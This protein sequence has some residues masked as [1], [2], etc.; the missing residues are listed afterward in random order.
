MWN[1]LPYY[2][3]SD[4]SFESYF[5]QSMQNKCLQITLRG[6]YLDNWDLCKTGHLQTLAWLVHISF[7]VWDLCKITQ[8]QNKRRQSDDRFSAWVLCKI[9][10]LQNRRHSNIGSRLVWDL[11]KIEYFQLFSPQSSDFPTR[12][13]AYIKLLTSKTEGMLLYVFIMFETYVKSN[14]SKTSST[15]RMVLR[16]M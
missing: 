3:R 14:A 12:F 6:K 2:H 5:L 1:H 7:S 13:V 9:K 11:C 16:P 15:E 10:C 4:R 8:L